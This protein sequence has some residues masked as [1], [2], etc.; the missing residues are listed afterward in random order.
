MGNRDMV[1]RSICGDVAD[2]RRNTDMYIELES[3][4]D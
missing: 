3:R 1:E 4:M 2:R